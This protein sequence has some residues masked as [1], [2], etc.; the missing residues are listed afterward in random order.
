MKKQY[1][2]L[3]LLIVILSIY[4]W[5]HQANQIHYKLPQLKQI[6]TEDISKVKINHLDE[7]IIIKKKNSHWL[8]GPNNYPADENRIR[9]LIKAIADL[10]IS[11]L[12]STS[13]QYDRYSLTDENKIAVK[14]WQK[15]DVI[16]NFEIG[17]AGEDYRSA[18]IK[19]ADNPNIYL[20]QE[21]LR[22]KF[23]TTVSNLRD[24]TVLSFNT[25]KIKTIEIEKQDK[26][27]VL[28]K[29]IAEIS[30][31][32]K[33]KQ[34]KEPH[35]EKTIWKTKKDNKV[36]TQKV[37]NL[38]QTVNNL[39]CENYLEHKS[40]QDLQSST[41]DYTLKFV[42][43]SKEHTLNIYSQKEKEDIKYWGISSDNDYSFEL[44]KTHGERIIDSIN[45]F[46][47]TA[48]KSN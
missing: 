3:V 39:S 22:R 37:N 31:A 7:D 24:K 5:K 35:R 25:K 32:N 40:K 12:V 13:K 17:K 34:R 27:M 20:T 2:I 45:S 46:F 26:N 29:E 38:L 36:E 15:E 47:N 19:L 28:N 30:K 43:S 18:Y 6:S 48:S 8:L 1:I 11:A 9:D 16:R 21:N 14:A 10:K 23:N 44:A 41:S 33:D 42:S 4:L